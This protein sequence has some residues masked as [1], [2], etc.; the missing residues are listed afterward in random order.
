MKKMKYRDKV[1]NTHYSNEEFFN[2]IMSCHQVDDVWY[3]GYLL[4]LSTVDVRKLNF[5]KSCNHQDKDQE[6]ISFSE[7]KQ[8]MSIISKQWLKNKRKIENQ[9][10]KMIT[11]PNIEQIGNSLLWHFEGR[12]SIRSSFI[13][14]HT[15]NETIFQSRKLYLENTEDFSNHHPNNLSSELPIILIRKSLNASHHRSK[16]Y[17]KHYES[18]DI[19]MHDKWASVVWNAFQYA[20][21]KAVGLSEIHSINL[22]TDN[23]TF[24]HDFPDTIAGREYWCEQEIAL[25]DKNNKRP[26]G[27]RLNNHDQPLPQWNLISTSFTYHRITRQPKARILTKARSNSLI[28][29]SSD[30][31]SSNRDE[32]ISAVTDNYF[33]WQVLRDNH[34]LEAYHPFIIAQTGQESSHMSDSVGSDYVQSTGKGDERR[35]KYICKLA[36]APPISPKPILVVIQVCPTGRGLPTD[37]SQIIS[38]TAR[39]C[40]LWLEHRN[41]RYTKSISGKLRGQHN[42]GDWHG[43][44]LELIYRQKFQIEASG[45]QRY[46]IG[47]IT[48]G[49][50]YNGIRKERS[51]GLADPHH[52]FR[53]F[54]QLWKMSLSQ[55]EVC[56]KR[57]WNSSKYTLVLIHNPRSQWLRPALLNY[58]Q[59]PE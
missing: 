1:N 23:V 2:F 22:I 44:N 32:S 15:L 4:P 16:K 25:K 21:L 39:D 42:T 34:L 5:T 26:W 14:S 20:G 41:N 55:S 27:K 3:D 18:W 24:P 10:K 17:M 48:S 53:L 19:L 6:N 51:I 38:P 49:Q 30:I 7:D 40:Q 59:V 47:Y 28:Q 57:G 31:I 37:G 50:K 33:Q 29:E 43:I 56:H 52:L 12:E 58:W 9:K 13:P 11:W 36:P 46:I 45:E 35:N 54:Q 8:R